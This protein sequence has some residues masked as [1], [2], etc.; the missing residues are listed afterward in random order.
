MKV[1]LLIFVALFA[2]TAQAESGR[3]SSGR[4]R[5]GFHFERFKGGS[6]DSGTQGF[7]V[8][9][10]H[11]YY[12]Y[13]G[14]NLGLELN[15]GAPRDGA[16]ADNNFLYA[17]MT[18]GWDDTFA[19][20]FYY[21]FSLLVG[22]GYGSSS[23]LGVSGETFALQPQVGI[24]VVIVNGYRLGFYP[25]YL[26]TPGTSGLSAITFSLR[27]ERKTESAPGKPVND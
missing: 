13:E 14:L 23:T 16:I 12:V 15:A 20:I 17:G 22:Y 9:L 8:G 7:M 6:T 18:V 21:D 5:T 27:F 10:R 3:D 19:K 24:G 2:V 25:G 11:S 4:T 26:Y 1:W